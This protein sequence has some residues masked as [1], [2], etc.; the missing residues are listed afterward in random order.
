MKLDADLQAELLSLNQDVVRNASAAGSLNRE[1]F[2]L[3]YSKL[4]AEAGD[5]PEELEPALFKQLKNCEVDGYLFELGEDLNPTGDLYIATCDYSSADELRTINIDDVKKHILGL[6][7]FLNIALASDKRIESQVG[8]TE[9]ELAIL[10]RNN[11]EIIKRIKYLIFTNAVLNVYEQIIEPTNAQGVEISTNV[12]DLR[13]YSNMS[14]AGYDIISI[15]IKDYSSLEIPC[16]KASSESSGIESYLLAMQGDILANI[17]HKYG[18]RL[19]EQ[20]VRTYLRNQSTVN[21]GI[22]ETIKS[23]PTMFLAYNNGLT[24]TASSIE[25]NRSSDGSLSIVSIK[26][27]QIVNGGQTTASIYYAKQSKKYDLSKVMVQIKLSVVTKD[28][29]PEIVPFI[30]RYANSQNKVQNTDFSAT[31]AVQMKIKQLSLEVNSPLKP[32]ELHSAR[33]FFERMRGEYRNMTLYTSK[34]EKKKIEAEYPKSQLIEKTDLAKW[35]LSFDCRPYTVSQGAQKAFVYYWKTLKDYDINQVNEDWFKS[36]VAKGIIFRAL[37]NAIGKTD[38][39]RDKK[40]LKAQNITYTIAQSVHQIQ[41]A[42]YGLNLPKIWELQVVP[43]KLLAWFLQVAEGVHQIINTPPSETSNPAEFCKKEFCWTKYIKDNVTVPL[44]S[45]N[46]YLISFDLVSKSPLKLN[47][48]KEVTSDSIDPIK[49]GLYL[50]Q[51]AKNKRW[52]SPKNERAL[53]SLM[54]GIMP[55]NTRETNALKHLFVMMEQK[56]IP[57]YPKE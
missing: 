16:L 54:K 26:D 44:D 29:I 35:V 46:E 36:T 4:I 30:S 31:T 25:C 37:D 56:N 12:V 45:I 32:G 17:Y 22:L 11:S 20:N 39:Y 7:S 47:P 34:S 9:Y 13:R 27:F 19:L 55:K 3:I 38:W 6:T 15:N 51:I 42:G 33:W 28:K 49:W 21:K 23:E 50:Y 2:F 41:A 10:M 8:S 40:A 1:E 43:S 24:A 5:S 53:K 48:Q 57:K 14:R 52:L 18:Q